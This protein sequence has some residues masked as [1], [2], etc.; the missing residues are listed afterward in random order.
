MSRPTRGDLARRIAIG[1]LVVW[2]AGSLMVASDLIDSRGA[3][4]VAGWV[5]IF[6]VGLVLLYALLRSFVRR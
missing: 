5:A 6:A 4:F 1:V 3:G 2:G